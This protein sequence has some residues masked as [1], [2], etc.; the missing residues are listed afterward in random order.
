MKLYKLECLNE[1]GQIENNGYYIYK[2]NANK[3]KRYLDCDRRNEIYGIKQ[4]V[5]EIETK[6]KIL[7]DK[8]KEL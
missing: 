6:D 5:I 1:D 2:E 8:Y 4:N 7:I 3:A